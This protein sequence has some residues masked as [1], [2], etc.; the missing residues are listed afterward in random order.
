MLAVAAILAFAPPVSAEH[1]PLHAVGM[2][3]P[4]APGASGVAPQPSTCLLEEG[5]PCCVLAKAITTGDATQ[6]PTVQDIRSWDW[7]LF[8]AIDLAADGPQPVLAPLLEQPGISGVYRGYDHLAGKAGW[9]GG[10]AWEGLTGAAA[11]DGAG[12]VG[13]KE[14]CLVWT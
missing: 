4:P 9:V 3:A 13:Y 5:L 1:D 10:H 7:V 11:V 8:V 2:V 12:A 6:I 14:E